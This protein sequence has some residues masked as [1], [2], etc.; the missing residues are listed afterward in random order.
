MLFG[1]GGLMAELLSR[2]LMIARERGMQQK[3]GLAMSENKQMLAL[4]QEAGFTINSGSEA[5]TSAMALDLTQ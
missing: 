4:A 2:C 5:Q 3:E 1:Q